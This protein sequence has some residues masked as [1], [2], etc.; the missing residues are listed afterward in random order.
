MP[1]RN[2]FPV[3]QDMLDRPR[4]SALIQ[5]G[6]QFPL[7][8][9]LA[10]PGYGKTQAIAGYLAQTDA[11]VLWL[12][13]GKLDNMHVHF[14]EHLTHAAEQEFPEIAQHM[15]TIGFPHT[16]V[17]MDSFF[18]Y[19]SASM[20][21]RKTAIWVFD[22]YG[23]I[24]DQHIKEFFRMFSEL[25]LEN[26]SA[27]LLSN[28]LNRIDSVA[29]LS[30]NQFLI[31]GHDL[32][33]TLDE[34]AALYEL[35]DDHLDAAQLQ[36][37]EQYT[38]GWPL[39]VHLLASNKMDVGKGH[40]PVQSDGHLTQM[41]ITLLFEERFFAVYA[42]DMQRVLIKL[43]VLSSFT[44]TI[45]VMLYP[46][47]KSDLELLWNH[48]FIS[49]E[50][51][52]G[53]YFFHNLY[54]LFLQHK[55]Y[56]LDDEERQNIL[57]IAADCFAQAGDSLRAIGYYHQSGDHR[58]MLQT[59][60]HFLKMHY[61]QESHGISTENAEYFIDLLDSLPPEVTQQYP[62]SD[63]LRAIIYLNTLRLEEA[64]SILHQLE[65]RL[66]YADTPEERELLGETLAAIGSI[67]MMLPQMDFSVYFERACGY[68]PNGTNQQNKKSL[69][70]QNNHTFSML[71]KS[72]GAKERME[73]EV[74]RAAPWISKLRDG[75]M[76]GFEYIFSAESAYLS[77]RLDTAQQ[78]AY[79]AAY[80]AESNA[81]HD[82]VCNAYFLLAKVAFL[83][84][85]YIEMT[86]Q[87]A[88]VREYTE[89]FPCGVTKDICDTVESWYYIKL[90]E[91]GN[92]PK[93]IFL[94][95]QSDK[96]VLAHDRSIIV[97]ANYLLENGEYAKLV[98]LLEHPVG[99][100]LGKSIWHDRIYA[101]IYL[102]LAHF[103]LKNTQSAMQVL[104]E[105]YD[106]TYQNGIMTPFIEAEEHMCAILAYVKKQ[107]TY[108]FDPEW[109]VMVDKLSSDFA[110]RV[111]MVRS[112]YRK[113]NPKKTTKENPLTSRE[114]DVLY[115]LSMGLTR[116]EIAASQ[117]I[118]INTVKTFTRS[119]Y[120]KLNASNRA[121]AV[122]IAISR[123][124]ID[125]PSK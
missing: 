117:Y 19:L 57:Q 116:E 25:D 44:N 36:E 38:E 15:R 1:N 82:L 53:Q 98:G 68:L 89:K 119:I 28:V 22:D 11:K 101:Y 37:I 40:S 76:S 124:Y 122:S 74:Y 2:R 34:I 12:R 84:G 118:S 95:A 86:K 10:G 5:H 21:G 20:M 87:V 90:H 16:A 83:N 60:S 80:K 54:G 49:G 94:S 65:Q 105:A 8:V 102:S 6:L 26:F 69:F 43:S 13:L 55:Q 46:G 92:V 18:A 91:Y 121:E 100:F 125:I 107:S 41:A 99:L 109:R 63:Y 61:G 106:M 52:T 115:A 23:E 111:A 59:I 96:P 45:A 73:R 75:G 50:P 112:V 120:T 64:E 9:M 31:L 3:Y 17:K 88:C 78:Y 4:V 58:N 85:D 93:G 51:S 97:Y 30:H 79:R 56:L 114:M 35:H 32:R 33:F 103:Y 110:K 39:P 66:L 81:Q 7:L 77:N 67:H 108:A 62:L 47:E 113:N 24:T 70:V 42:P 123:G 72:P 27:V 29:N 104:W 14:W 71:D 48:L